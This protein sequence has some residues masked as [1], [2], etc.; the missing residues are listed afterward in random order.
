MNLQES[1]DVVAALRTNLR[2][3]DTVFIKGSH[4]SGAW[5]IAAKL[6]EIMENTHPASGSSNSGSTHAEEA[7]NAA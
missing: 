4:G 2:S 1:N 7:P 3:G 5:R 6:L